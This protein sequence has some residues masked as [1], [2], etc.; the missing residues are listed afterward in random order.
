MS[1]KSLLKV[2]KKR[3]LTKDSVEISF[4]IE[5]NLEKK[6]SFKPGQYLTLE[7]EINGELIKRSYS[8]CSSPNE[9]NLKTGIKIVKNGKF[10]NYAVKHLKVGDRVMVSHPQGKFLLKKDLES[11]NIFFLAAGSGITPILSMIKPLLQSDYMNKVLLVTEI[12][13][14]KLKC[15]LRSR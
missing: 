6:F 1:K 5:K 10:S 7:K 9:I 15:L 14:K 8:I 13:V 2:I 12:K 11:K 3:K 4:E